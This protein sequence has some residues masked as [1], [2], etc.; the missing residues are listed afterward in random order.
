VAAAPVLRPFYGE[1]PTPER[2]GLD[3]S[4]YACHPPPPTRERVPVTNQPEPYDYRVL[5]TTTRPRFGGLRWWFVCPLVVRGYACERRVGKLYLPPGSRYF[6]CRHCHELTYRSAQEHD[7]RVNFLR[8]N[9]A[10][11][12]MLL[13]GEP[14]LARLGL[15][16]KAIGK[17]TGDLAR[18]EGRRPK[19]GRRRGGRG[20]P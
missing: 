19:P 7:K 5:L 11:L 16:L 6:G 15:A 10:A 4:L 8:R 12:G 17:A 2:S 1:A 18:L 13:A 3:P 9:P 14:D 20:V